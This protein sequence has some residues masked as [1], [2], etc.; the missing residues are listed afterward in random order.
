[1][2]AAN[3]WPKLKPQS[4][5]EFSSIHTR[6]QLPTG[7]RL[8][9]DLRKSRTSETGRGKNP[10][11]VKQGKLAE[12]TCQWSPIVHHLWRNFPGEALAIVCLNGVRGDIIKVLSISKQS[13]SHRDR[14][15]WAVSYKS[16]HHGQLVFLM[17][18]DKWSIML[19][20]ILMSCTS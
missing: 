20:S 1:M 11:S 18:Q 14:N 12:D 4:R 8:P 17:L 7:Y 5:V 9:G 6:K 13:E 15:D 16:Q 10:V 3:S 2:A 19:L